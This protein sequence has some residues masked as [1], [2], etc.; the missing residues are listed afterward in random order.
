MSNPHRK[1]FDTAHAEFKAAEKELT[2]QTDLHRDA[3]AN[4][5]QAKLK[6]AA[7]EREGQDFATSGK[8]AN[9]AAANDLAA[10]QVQAK[11][12]VPLLEN[13]VQQ[14]AHSL[15]MA[16]A[17]VL[18]AEQVCQK[19]QR[20]FYD[21]EIDT[22]LDDLLRTNRSALQRLTETL[23]CH[24]Q[25]FGMHAGMGTLPALVEIPLANAVE[26]F[27]A[28]DARFHE[29]VGKGLKG[30]IPSELVKSDLIMHG[31][32]G[33]IPASALDAGDLKSIARAL[34]PAEV[35]PEHIPTH[36][37]VERLRE[38]T[39]RLDEGGRAHEQM[40]TQHARLKTPDSQREL[41]LAE[42]NLAILQRRFDLAQTALDERQLSVAA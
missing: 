12:V 32:R 2:R 11:H 23:S 1:A 6:L 41:T 36:V 5:A 35:N 14:I 40:K 13:S 29:N 8:A 7:L 27:L 18:F 22:G 31:E 42:H 16:K 21:F 38:T 17:R 24:A 34:V 20:A 28:N 39:K 9:P 37:L 4:L 3:A 19:H 30:Q 25:L 15:N 26:R 33:V 10:R